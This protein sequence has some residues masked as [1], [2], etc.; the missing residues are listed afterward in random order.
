MQ[1]IAHRQVGDECDALARETYEWI[2][3][4]LGLDCPWAAN[5]RELE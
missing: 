2:E 5:F 4:E 3:R 1:F